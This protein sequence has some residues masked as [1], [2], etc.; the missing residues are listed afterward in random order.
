MAPK[1]NT[2]ST[3][4]G[5]DT[6]KDYSK[7]N[8]GSPL[9][10]ELEIESV[11]VVVKMTNKQRK[12]ALKEQK[13][14]NKKAAQN[15]STAENDDVSP[16]NSSG[17]E[18]IDELLLECDDGANNVNKDA[19]D[20]N[21]CGR[22]RRRGAQRGG[23]EAER[24]EKESSKAPKRKQAAANRRRNQATRRFLES[25]QKQKEKSAT[26]YRRLTINGRCRIQGR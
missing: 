17:D 24:I 19:D 20:V 4:K 6:S 11:P 5:K 22:G 21:K 3:Q 23:K 18:N 8:E 15:V 26:Y 12:A 13:Q 10:D 2:W 9:P 25:I 7:L 16:S 14:K 1:R